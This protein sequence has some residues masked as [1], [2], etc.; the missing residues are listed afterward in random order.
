MPMWIWVNSCGNGGSAWTGSARRPGTA[1]QTPRSAST[2]KGRTGRNA[3]HIPGRCLVRLRP[4]VAAA[5]TDR[6]VRRRQAYRENIT[7]TVVSFEMVPVP[8]GTVTVAGQ[9]VRGRAVLHR[10]HRGDVGSVRRLRARPRRAQGRCRR[11]CRRASVA[12]VRRAGL[13]VGTRRLPGDQRRAPG[14][15]GLRASGSRR[16]PARTIACRPKPSGRTPPRSPPA[17]TPL[18]PGALDA[19]AW[20]RGNASAR[21]H[22][23]GDEGGRCARA[24]RSLRQRRRVGHDRRR[25]RVRH[26]RRLVSRPARDA[27]T[28]RARDPGRHVERAR[29]AAPQEP[30]VALRWTVR[31]LSAGA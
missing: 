18:T 3:F 28:R 16:R 23:V 31:R 13:R 4:G 15:G 19:L 24:V 11:G 22:P 1:Y 7:G 9:T 8:G 10:P 25:A 30:L 26:A 27:R 12:A 2:I 20:H 21:T 17:R 14:G 6:S 29:S 5:G